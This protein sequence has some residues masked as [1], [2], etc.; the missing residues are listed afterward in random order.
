[1]EEERIEWARRNGVRIIFRSPRGVFSNLKG[2]GFLNSTPVYNGV[3]IP[4][5]SGHGA[6][7]PVACMRQMVASMDNATG[8]RV[9]T[10][11]TVLTEETAPQALTQSYTR[12]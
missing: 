2:R 7:V 4:V 12:R 10:A 11:T 6:A 8:R 9:C 1:M 5:R 3:A